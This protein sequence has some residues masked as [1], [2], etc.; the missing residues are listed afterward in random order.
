[1]QNVDFHGQAWV[2]ELSSGTRIWSLYKVT[3][4]LSSLQRTKNIVVGCP[5]HL[6]VSLL[7]NFTASGEIL[8]TIIRSYTEAFW[9]PVLPE[10]IW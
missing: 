8:F 5:C 9:F 1:M 3:Q 10:Q 7:R 4:K 2:F 6:F